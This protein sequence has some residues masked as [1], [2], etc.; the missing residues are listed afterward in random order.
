MDFYGIL[1]LPQPV[2]SQV[3]KFL[4]T[5]MGFNMDISWWFRIL[6]KMADRLRATNLNVFPP[7]DSLDL[8]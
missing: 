7:I 1:L 6:N 8:D 5:S 4:F 3:W 2:S